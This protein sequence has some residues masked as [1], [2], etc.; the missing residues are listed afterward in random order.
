MSQLRDLPRCVSEGRASCGGSD[1]TSAELPGE[2][3]GAHERQAW[4]KRKRRL[5]RVIAATGI[6]PIRPAGVYPSNASENAKLFS[7]GQ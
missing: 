6:S 3:I 2:Q 4:E 1:Q 7:N 5:Y